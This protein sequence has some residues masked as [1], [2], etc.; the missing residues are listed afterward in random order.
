MF[1]IWFQMQLID[2]SH[3]GKPSG[4]GVGWNITLYTKSIVNLIIWE[5]FKYS[6]LSLIRILYYKSD[7]TFCNYFVYICIWTSRVMQLKH[8][9]LLPL[10]FTEHIGN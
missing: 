3:S 4:N 10:S 8:C 2:D 9:V 5:D 6:H 7:Y 1:T